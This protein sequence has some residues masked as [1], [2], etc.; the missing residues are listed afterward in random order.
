MNA[1]KRRNINYAAKKKT[2]IMRE[3]VKITN[4]KL[5]I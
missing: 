2:K 3:H 4:K 1:L 5:N